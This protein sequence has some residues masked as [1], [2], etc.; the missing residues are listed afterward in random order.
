MFSHVMIGTNDL[1]KAKTFYDNLLSTLEVRPARVDG[2]RIFY[3]TKTGV[4]SVTKPINGEAATPA[5]GGTIGFAANSPE[6]VNAWHTAGIAAGG[7]PC[8]DPPGIRQ[9]PGVNLY[10]AYLRDLDGNKICAMHRMAS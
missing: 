10:I 3:I 6:Q 4:F 7:V 5:N 2:H 9:G 1:D 8:E